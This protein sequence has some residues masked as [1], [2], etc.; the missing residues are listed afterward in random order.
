MKT[1][2]CIL[3][4]LITFVS[5]TK[6]SYD[7]QCEIVNKRDYYVIRTDKLIR[8]E[9]DRPYIVDDCELESSNRF[10][11]YDDALIESDTVVVIFYRLI[12]CY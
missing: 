5:C 2:L 7:C 11:Q 1:V 3:V 10:E 9:T 6:E 8:S 4:I 12:D